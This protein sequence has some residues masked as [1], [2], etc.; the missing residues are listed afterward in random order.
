MIRP[1]FAMVAI[2]ASV[3][4]ALGQA[5][6]V[7]V[8]DSDGLRAAFN[9]ATPGTVIRLEQGTYQPN[10][11]LSGKSGGPVAPIVIEGADPANPPVF[12]GG[13][14]ALHLTSCSHV[15]LRNL[16]ARGQKSNGLNID[17]GSQPGSTHHVVIENVR[18]EDIGP[19][20]NHDAIKLSGL[21]DFEVRDCTLH[22]WGGQGIDMVGC[23]RGLI[24]GCSFTGKQGFS[25]DTGIT[26]KGGSREVT[27][28]RCAFDRAADRGVNVGGSTGDPFYR[29]LDAPYE[30]AAITV[31]GCTFHGGEAPIAFVGVDGAVF[32]YNT[33]YDPGKW[34]CRILQE[35]SEP[36]FTPSSNGLLER[37][38]FVFKAARMS[39][40]VNV[41]P[42]TKSETFIFKDNLW[43]AMDNPAASKLRLPTAEQGGVH[44]VD[45]KLEAPDKGSFEPLAPEAAGFGATALKTPANA[46]GQGSVRLKQRKVADPAAKKPLP[47]AKVAPP[48]GRDWVAAMKAVHAKGTARKGS[49][50]QIGDSITYT[51]AFLAPM[52][53]EK[54]AG[55]DA[56]AARIDAKLLNERKGPP[57]ANYSGWVAQQ[58]LDAIGAVLA[59]EQPEIAVVMYGT[60][61]VRKGVTPADYRRQLDGIVAACLEA[62][63]V[64]IVSTIPPMLNMDDRVAEFNA[65]VRTVAADRKIPLVDFHGE[66]LARQPGTDWDGTLLGKGD[67][68]P[69]G[70]KNLDFSA[71]NLRVCG[72]ALRNHATLKV[73]Q[74]VIEKCF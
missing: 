73:M 43:F 72:Y 13:N 33:V 39:E 38:I 29:P 5:A 7:A 19:Q 24:E 55:F 74:E 57:H 10:V 56:V 50:S 4:A 20:G 59:A 44:G 28:R 41:G 49:V 1:N 12:T 21:D 71:D 30:A 68:H 36:R 27:V 63:C 47:E 2:A 25:G 45:P 15:V 69:T 26:T 32:R 64:P 14:E 18:V 58:G 51:K 40:V 42:G 31:E 35:R 53:W 17:D 37:N 54:P 65:A 48:A 67:V 9:A 23:H 46:G 60:N 16:V 61:D 70:G 3:T 11:F 52:A 66:I 6:P 22:G 8:R 62:G 34:I